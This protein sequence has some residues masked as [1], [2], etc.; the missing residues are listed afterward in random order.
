MRLPLILFLALL[1]SACNSIGYYVQSIGGQLAVLDRQRPIDEV[2]ADPA[3]PPAVRTKLRTVLRIRDFASS[4]LGLPDNDSYRS[5]AD[6]QRP[7]VVWNVFVAPR[8]EMRLQQ[9]CFPV[10]GCVGYRGY[11]AEHEA[12]EFA[13]QRAAKGMDTYVAGITAYSTLGWFDD[14]LL[15]TVIGYSEARIA[16]LIFH[17]LAHQQLYV[18]G[19]TAFNEAFATT[20]EM[21]GVHRW[22]SAQGDAAKLEIDIRQRRRQTQFVEWVTRTRDRLR[23]MYAESIDERQKAIRKATILAGLRKQS[24]ELK[25]QWGGYAGFD[26][27]FA[28]DLNNAQLAAVTTYRDHVPAL[29]HL[30]VKQGGDFAAFYRACAELGKLPRPEREMVLMNLSSVEG[31]VGG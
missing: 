11:F 23:T 24:A 20:V 27:W 6:L 28:R 31:E 25:R 1:S 18:E 14:P 5:Y 19:D 9:W 2:L 16:G 29:Q 4:Q 13:A 12:R 8:F 7:F 30:L 22:L 26:H 17:E 3:T 15:S 10:A 21:E